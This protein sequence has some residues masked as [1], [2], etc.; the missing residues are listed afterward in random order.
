MKGT[1]TLKRALNSEQIRTLFREL[2]MNNV[3]C[4]TSPKNKKEPYLYKEIRIN[5][6]WELSRAKTK[7]EV[8]KIKLINI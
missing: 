6:G 1:I 5:V 4:E 3:S 7:I 2:L 8:K